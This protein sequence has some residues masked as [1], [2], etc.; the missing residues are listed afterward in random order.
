[1]FPST[2]KFK[3]VIVDRGVFPKVGKFNKGG[4]EEEFDEA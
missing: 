4:Q 3:A 1:M 2:K